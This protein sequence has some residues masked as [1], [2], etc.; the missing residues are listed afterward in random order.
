MSQ[1]WEE[2]SRADDEPAWYWVFDKLGFWPSTFASAW[3][4][5]REPSPS[6]T[7]DLSAG[8]PSRSSAEFRV[9]PLAV[10][11][12]ELASVLLTALRDCVR[13]DEWVYALDWQH[14]S[15]RLW[16]HRMGERDEWR[17]PPFRNGDYSVFL[18]N[19][20]RFGTLGHPWERTLCVYGEGLVR[21]VD[22]RGS[23]VLT[24][25]L[26]RDGHAVA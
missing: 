15:Y 8:S 3:P 24:S 19:D 25:V 17:V 21:A 14:Q 9:S 1:A 6:T 2:L 11:E 7:W 4:G 12:A 16:P 23:D 5:F 26:R 10:T 22:E 13:P 18:A 20:F